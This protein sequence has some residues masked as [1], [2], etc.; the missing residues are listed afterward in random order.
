MTELSIQ[1]PE[2][3]GR[4]QELNQLKQALDNTI[5]GNGSTIFI[6][7][8]AGIGKTR[9]TNEIIKDAEKQNAQILR[10]WCLAESLEPLMPMRTA[11]R[12]AGLD[13]IFIG[14]KPP[15]LLSLYLINK[16]GMLISKSEREE[17][18]IEPDIF[19]GMLSAVSNF[20]KDS[21]EGM[22]KSSTGKGLNVMGYDNYR[23]II[24]HSPNCSLAAV[25][26]GKENEFFLDDL[27]QT[28][29]SIELEYSGIIK[30]WSGRID[31]VTGTK[32]I[33][34]ELMNLG[35]YEGEFLVDD[36]KILQENLFDNVLLGIQRL[37]RERPVIL[38]LD[39]IHW[40]DPTSLNLLH[41]LSRNIRENQILILGTY[42]PED[43]IDDDE[44]KPHQLKKTMQNMS[45]E[46]LF[47]SI[48]ISRLDKA[49]TKNLVT[50]V[51]VSNNLDHGFFLRIHSETEG[52]PFY[53]L[54]VI[55]LL[56]E[57]G[58]LES[59]DNVWKLATKMEELAI[60]SKIYDVV[61]RRLDRLK[62][63]QRDILESASVIG[64]E[65]SSEII[66]TVLGLNRIMLL[67]NLSEI[68]NNHKLIH[69]HQ[70]IYV[71]DHA[72]VREVLYNGIM[73]ELRQEYHRIT[74]EAILE[75]NKDNPDNM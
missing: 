40:C 66:G 43:I 67:R 17:S 45:R 53:I 6:S 11:F 65:F 63:E 37:S 9:L 49:N 24:E 58:S 47:S 56:I 54:E 21:L 55:K 22:D 60:P 38:F 34:L 36:P 35:K 13:H 75:Q 16:A 57:E 68:E 69:S 28:L 51:L 18:G 42:R 61:K 25:I 3:V 59:D 52:T 70:K 30:N 33:L 2:F 29:S 5:Q 27:K 4:E 31:D 15:K 39:D 50:N 32:E 74:G 48:Q 71:F 23:I 64:E 10:G 44:G 19:A 1:V 14:E 8:E 7:G 46:D 62:G 72:K 41:Y 20:V 26:S 73:D 12:E